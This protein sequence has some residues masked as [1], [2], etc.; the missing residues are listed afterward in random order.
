MAQLKDDCFAFGGELM[1]LKDA[2]ETLAERVRPVTGTES[3]ALRAAL[4]R[5]LAEDVTADRDVPP[6]NNSAVDGYAVYF[7]DLDPK[8]ATRLPVVGRV[9]AGHPLG[10]AAEREEAVRIFTGA[11]IP[12]G[13]DGTQASGPDTVFMEEDCERDGDFVILP[14]GLKRGSNYRVAGEDVKKGAVVLR[15]G[16]RLRA[17]E[18]GLLASL[19]KGALAVRKRL[20]AAVFSTGDEVKDP[21]GAAPEGC[22]F[23]ANRFAVMALLENLGAEVT[24]LGIL[25]DKAQAVG[26][27]LEAAAESHD[28]LV[29]SG[30][31]SA[32]E[33]DHVRAAVARHGRIHFW[34]L[35]IRPGRPIALGQIGDA[36]FLG[37]PGNPVAAMVTF[38]IIGRPLVLL[39]GGAT[40]VTIA[41]YPVVAGFDY[42]KKK[43]RR[44]WAR[45][46]IEANGDGRPVAHKYRSSGAGILS[47]MVEADGLLELGEDMDGMKKGAVVDFLPFSGVMG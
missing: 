36:A 9:A 42:K 5:V 32:G 8:A 18:I 43:G 37:L 10:R 45:V 27:A 1:P 13:A 6:L 39:L 47:S 26:N 44:E 16:H 22:I 23:D 17:Q 30:G 2:L 12:M 20:K 33:E 34:R 38:L 28:L 35:A 14:P 4:G 3:V 29:T 15:Q 19:G 7:A 31:V 24:D 21:S 41:R 40:E 25:P 11:A 46:R